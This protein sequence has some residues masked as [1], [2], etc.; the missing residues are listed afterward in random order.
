MAEIKFDIEDL[1]RF[2]VINRF[3]RF[4][5][6]GP[7]SGNPSQSTLL[8]PMPQRYVAVG[9]MPRSIPEGVQC[10]SL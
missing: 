6:K 9:P 1:E 7:V 2:S 3:A 8:K 4:H 10:I 5:S